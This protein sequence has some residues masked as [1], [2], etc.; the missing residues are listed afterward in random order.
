MA[1]EQKRP[2][3]RPS[4]MT[5]ETLAQLRE[6]FLMGATDEEACV[7]ADIHPA[8]LYR[9]QQDNP[10]YCEEKKAWKQ[11]PVM[12][13]RRTVVDSLDKLENAKWYLGKKRK[14]EFDESSGEAGDGTV[15]INI[16]KEVRNHG[17][18]DAD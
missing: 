7:Y 10:D 8:T 15:T 4:E 9:Y 5:D 3:G 2:I 18:E 13:A 12:K 6:A 14:D 1:S 11:N 17:A 16:V